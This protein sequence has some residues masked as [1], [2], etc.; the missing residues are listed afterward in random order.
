MGNWGPIFEI[1]RGAQNLKLR[2]GPDNRWIFLVISQCEK[3]LILLLTREPT[4]W[5][6]S[7]LDNSYIFHQ[8][9]KIPI[10]WTAPEAIAYRKFT[11][12]SDVWSYGIVMWEVMSYGE[13]PYWN[14]TNQDVIKAIDEGYR[15]TPPM[16]RLNN[17]LLYSGYISRVFYFGEFG[18]LTKFTNSKP[19]QTQ[20][21]YSLYTIQYI[22]LYRAQKPPN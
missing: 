15:L 5:L 22:E 18:E 10:R 9:G 13:R 6:E 11:T 17:K 7:Q 14:W 16:V 8:G 21:L 4:R 19:R 3:N 12:A 20:T 2:S 1:L